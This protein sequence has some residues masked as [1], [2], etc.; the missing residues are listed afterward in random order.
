MSAIL[1]ELIDT[2]RQLSDSGLVAGA[3]G[4]VSARDG[5]DMWISPS[6]FS[7][8]NDTLLS[9][10]VQAALTLPAGG[11]TFFCRSREPFGGCCLAMDFG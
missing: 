4:N 8:A 5:D 1:E 9:T 11:C 7:F 3:G 6:G 10:N 2:A